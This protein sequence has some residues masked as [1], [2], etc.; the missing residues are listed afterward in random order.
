MDQINQRDFQTVR[1]VSQFQF[2]KKTIPILLSLSVFSF[3]FSYYSPLPF[4]LHSF[5]HDGTPF[6]IQTVSFT[7]HRN[8][9]FLLCNGILVFLITSSGLIT[10]P[11]L[12]SD[13]DGKHIK[14]DGEDR[15]SIVPEFSEPKA[16]V[17]E[18]V[19]VE[20][21]EDH[22]SENGISVPAK[23]DENGL[24][25]AQDEDED[26]AEFHD[27]EEEEEGIGGLLS[28]EEL[29]KKCEDFIRKMKGIKIEAQHHL[30]MV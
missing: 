22:G 19:V 5:N 28:A 17:N 2:L 9:I 21:E 24:V 4:L 27:M 10:N 23:G 15:R 14:K 18:V 20:D 25:A 11:Q 6:S 16:L 13:V 30:I 3:L 1:Q 12:G 7:I 29:N 8:Y 26:E